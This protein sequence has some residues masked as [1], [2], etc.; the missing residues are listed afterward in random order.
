MVQGE[1]SSVGGTGDEK[2]IVKTL[3]GWRD[4][5]VRMRMGKR[6]TGGGKSIRGAEP[7]QD[8]GMFTD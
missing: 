2:S 3:E 7:D 5:L 8:G 6:L 4:E 1:E